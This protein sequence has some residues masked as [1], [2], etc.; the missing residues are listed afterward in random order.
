[1]SNHTFSN[2]PHSA[3]AVSR[4]WW[5]IT[6]IKP[7]LA[8]GEAVDRISQT[9]LNTCLVPAPPPNPP[10]IV[11]DGDRIS[12]TR[13]VEPVPSVGVAALLLKPTPS[14]MAVGRGS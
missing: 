12:Q 8:P 3:T 7:A 1:M 4:R 14:W 5:L 13:P 9:N 6:V 10:P 11:G 2:R